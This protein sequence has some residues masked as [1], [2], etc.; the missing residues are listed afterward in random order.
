M[1]VVSQRLSYAVAQHQ[2]GN[3][4]KAEAIYREL[5]ARA[6]RGPDPHHA[7]ALH[8]LGLIASE[9]GRHEA[10]SA[11]IVRAIEAGGPSPVYCVSLGIALSRQGKIGHAVACYRQALQ[12][13]PLDG[14][15]YALLGSALLAQHRLQEAAEAFRASARLAPAEAETHFELGNTLH[16][17]GSYEEAAQSYLRVMECEPAH[18]EACHNLGVTR[19]MQQ[20]PDEAIAAYEQAI[21]IR[22]HYPEPHNNLGALMQALRQDDRATYHYQEALRLAPDSLEVRYNL[23]LLNQE[24]DRLEEAVSSYRELLGRKPD[25]AEARNNLGNTLL[26]LRLPHDAIGCYRQTLADNPAS[27]EARW[28]LGVANLLLGRFDEGWEGHEWRF[29]QKGAAPRVF[30]QPMWDGSELHDRRILLHAEQ[31]LGDTL[32]FVRYAS[33][34]KQ[35]GGHVILE[36]QEPLYRLLSTVRGVDQLIAKG[37]PLPA[38]DCHAPLLSLP[39][40][41]RTTLATVPTEVPYIHVG[42]EAVEH[43]R[44]TIAAQAGSR[45]GLK[46]GLTWAGNPLHKNDRN[47]SLPARGLEALAGLENVVFFGLQKGPA[48]ECGLET[49]DL[50]GQSRDFFDTAAILLN[51]DL[52][53]SVDTS[54]AHLAGALGRPVLTLLPFAPD[55]RWM[56]DRADSPWY[57]SMK[58]YRQARRKDWMEVIQRL[59]AELE[60]NPCSRP[61]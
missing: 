55:W 25:H 17:M 45:T 60:S 53:V 26:A 16:A 5:I 3:L 39:G 6:P 23:A 24:R 33:L 51:L 12:S 14:K 13:S 50:V 41:F 52:I 4:A 21:R 38:F 46:V 54:V 56:L 11:L 20:R 1:P 47:R 27:A 22:P 36:C 28:N 9:A 40:I 34:V 59:R 58:L 31:G 48:P 30:P 44:E 8:L 37:S 43:W 49:I 42:P 18:A 61:S 35:R 2:A 32:Q 15:T 29:R 57:P 19:T 10:A 7:D